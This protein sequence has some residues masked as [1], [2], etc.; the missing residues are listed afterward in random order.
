MRSEAEVS[1]FRR[2]AGLAVASCK[3]CDGS[4]ANTECGCVRKYH[5][6]VEAYEA[7]LP[8]DFWYIKSRKVR[9]NVDVFNDVVKQ[10]VSRLSVAQRR[11]YGLLFSGSNGVGKSMF[12]S[13]VL[14][15]A[16]RRGRSAY[17]TTL[18]NLDHDLKSG[19]DDP[20]RRQRLELM[21]TSDFLGLDEMT[22]EAF[23]SLDKPTWIKTQ[24]E[25]I[26][27]HRFDE[28]KPVLMATNAS[29]AQLKE[30]YGPTIA[31]IV[32]GKYQVAMMEPGDVRAVVGRRAVKDMGY[33]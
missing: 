19:F 26:L 9:H 5:F 1:D 3:E 20:E 14:A 10:Y 6:E 30:V 31:S 32:A 11:G 22:K 16:I 13:Y 23:R 28:N 27:K 29:G 2:E 15:N 12:M 21:L 33:R 7:C 4:L 24:I 8:R 18:L 17:Y 25:R